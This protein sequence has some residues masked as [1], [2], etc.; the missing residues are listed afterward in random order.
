ML[1]GA[2]RI[3]MRPGDGQAGLEETLALSDMFR[4]TPR[5]VSHRFALDK[6]KSVPESGRDDGKVLVL[7]GAAGNHFLVSHLFLRGVISDIVRALPHQQ[8]LVEDL[9]LK[10]RLPEIVG[11]ACRVEDTYRKKASTTSWKTKSHTIT[12]K[13]NPEKKTPPISFFATFL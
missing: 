1:N 5:T 6:V 12:I 8:R 10:A 7:V 11:D 2:Q 9:K 13:R 3:G 4:Q